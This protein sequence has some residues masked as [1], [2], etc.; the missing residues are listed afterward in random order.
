MPSPVRLALFV[1]KLLENQMNQAPGVHFDSVW[2][3]YTYEQSLPS[4]LFM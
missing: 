4:E 2:L 1:L 3:V